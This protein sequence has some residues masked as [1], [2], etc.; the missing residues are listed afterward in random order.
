MIVKGVITLLCGVGLYVS[1]FMLNK[2]RRAARGEIEGPSVVQTPRAHLFG[3]PNSLVGALYYAAVGIAVWFVR[4]A[5]GELV[6]L[7]AILAAAATSL[8]LAYSLLF[9]TRRGCPFCWTS[10]ALN[11]AL[12]LLGTWL[13]LPN[14]LNR[15]A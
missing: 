8:Y 5:G 4:G 3:V 1:L 15:G 14:V 9:V 2:S 13:F 7:A 11:W 12:L 10:H 6:L